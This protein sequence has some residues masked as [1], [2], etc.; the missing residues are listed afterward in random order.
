MAIPG[1]TENSEYMFFK[2]LF[3]LAV[4]TLFLSS[5][6]WTQIQTMPNTSERP[7]AKA[8]IIEKEPVIDGEILNDAVW[9][10]IEP[11]GDLTQT[12]PNS[13]QPAS[14]KTEIRIGY[15]TNTLYVSVVCFDA[16]PDQL[17]VSDSRRDAS[18]D[19]MDGFLF[20]LDTYHDQQNGFMFGTNSIGIEYD[21]QVD[22]EGKGNFNANRQ[23][24][25]IIGGFNLNW[26]GSWEVKTQVGDYGWSAEFAI[27]FKT[28]R[29]KSGN[30]Q[31][32][33]LNFRRNIR[34]TNEVAFWA[35][36]PIEFDLKRLSLAG[37]LSGLDLQKPGN[38]K[39]IPYVLGKVERDYGTSDSNA[40]IDVEFGA[41]IKYSITP[42]MTL[43]LTYNTDFAQ[44][45]VDEV[46]INLDRFNLFFPEKR[47]FF[48]E[49]AGL[50][51]VGSPGEVD[52]FFSRR[53]GIGPD[54][55][56]VPIIGGA[57][58]SGKIN[59]TN[60]GLLS[61]FT[62]EVE[63][64][65]ITAN[66]FTVARIDHQLASRS[67]V[68]AIFVSRQGM[69]GMTDDYNQTYGIDG[70]WGI[71][72]KA[73]LSGF[74]AQSTTP[75]INDNRHAFKFQSQYEWN[76]LS[77]NGAYT[78][79]GEGFNPEVG[80]L[81]RTAFR[82]PEFRILYHVRPDDMIGLLE[83]RP[84][85]S[86]RGFWNFNGLL[87]TGF[88]HID[89]HWEWKSGLEIHTGINFTTEGVVTPFEIFE[90][91]IV[92]EGTYHNQEAQIIFLTNSSKSVY[93]STR[94]I[95]GG[96]FDGTRMANS[97]TLGI[98]VGEKFNTEFSLIHNDIKLENGSFTTDI[99][100]GRLTYSF[101]PRIYLQSLIQYNSVADIWSTN[102]RF[103]LL[104][105]ANSGLFIVY[106]EIRDHNELSNR[107]FTVKYSHVIDILH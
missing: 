36:M 43:D 46:Q 102:I 7:D 24:G 61:M 5:T 25:G 13:G 16:M 41:D 84:H 90:S 95:I 39:I 101:T 52:L 32:W 66:N 57:R 69:S 100:R 38:L 60:V 15:S 30:D 34:K 26:D 17:V 87:E 67:S 96:F 9:Q 23:Q 37:T 59:R 6:G 71:G 73:Q 104:E 12:Q 3:V 8:S 1:S 48:L 88:L 65:Q 11:I 86:Y 35:P 70:K 55:Q 4:G 27:P 63:E 20:I 28:L 94:S 79:V 92:S 82:K 22:N 93:I 89:N 14:E 31:I 64:E 107:S 54:G 72:Q 45:E 42:G 77:I 33:G 56:I 29:F 18:L 47:P 2:R 85:I 80:F 83:L 44:V 53:I 103:S 106:N 91:V 58:L 19:D 40:E 76:S 68:G 78:E 62:E 51:S 75:G 98:R 74:Y 10:M 49:N 81:Q 50:F 99:F 97:G 21:A 105:Q